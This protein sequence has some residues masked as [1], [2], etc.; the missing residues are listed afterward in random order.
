MTG[1]LV[2][3]PFDIE[4]TSDANTSAQIQISNLHSGIYVYT[5]SEDNKV[6]YKDKII[7]K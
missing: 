3:V 7:K 2:V 6:V 1:K 5:L 4:A